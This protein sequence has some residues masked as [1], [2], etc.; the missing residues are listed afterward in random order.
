[1][2]LEAKIV[3]LEKRATEAEA[4]LKKASAAATAPAA[5]GADNKAVIAKLQQLEKLISE[6]KAE[7]D[8]VRAKRDELKEENEKL[9]ALV[10]KGEYRIEH[11]LKTIE[12]LEKKKE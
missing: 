8:A 7:A 10:A 1:M 12:E 5:G 3:A 2:S 9:R 4:L 11:L 6:D